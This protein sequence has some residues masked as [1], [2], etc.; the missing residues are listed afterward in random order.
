[1]AKT[2]DVVQAGSIQLLMEEVNRRLEDG[3]ELAGNFAAAGP[4][5]VQPMTTSKSV[6]EVKEA[7][8]PKDLTDAEAH[9]KFL[10]QANSAAN[11][12]AMTRI[13]GPVPVM[14][15]I[16]EPMEVKVVATPLA[17]VQAQEKAAA[18]GAKVKK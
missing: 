3:W 11:K 7:K 12:E 6:K 14:P 1:M 16:N 2:Y 8:A 18:E 17:E 10:E 13:T 15:G 5:F 4:G 9:A